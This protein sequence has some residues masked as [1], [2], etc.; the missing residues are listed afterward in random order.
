MPDLDDKQKIDEVPET[1]LHGY[2]EAREDELQ[3]DSFDP[4]GDAGGGSPH[5]STP[6]FDAPDLTGGEAAAPAAGKS[7]PPLPYDSPGDNPSRETL[8]GTAG[9]GSA[10]GA[11]G[12]PAAP[13]D[14]EGAP[15]EAR[16]ERPPR[17]VPA[18]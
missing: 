18:G 13:H 9:A 16:S 14:P 8:D 2:K 10:T 15:A 4:T 17:S 5:P 3:H 7:L 6:T 11:L 1:P 12:G